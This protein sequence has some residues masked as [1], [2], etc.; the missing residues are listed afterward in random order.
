M[1]P[2]FFG[3]HDA[4][5]VVVSCVNEQSHNIQNLCTLRST[6]CLQIPKGVWWV[7]WL[8]SNAVSEEP[9]ITFHKCLQFFL[10]NYIWNRIISTLWKNDNQVACMKWW[11]AASLSGGFSS[12]VKNLSQ[13]VYSKFYR[14]NLNSVAGWVVNTVSKPLWVWGSNHWCI[15]YILSAWTFHYDVTEKSLCG[16]IGKKRMLLSDKGHWIGLF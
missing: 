13:K 1:L 7:L 6:V 12:Q 10:Y 14:V 8:R 16:V 3:W 9:Q 11:I 5:L 15:A 4:A 2:S